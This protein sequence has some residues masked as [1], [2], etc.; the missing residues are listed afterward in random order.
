MTGRHKSGEVAGMAG[1]DHQGGAHSFARTATET[2]I[3]FPIEHTPNLE[4][5]CVPVSDASLFD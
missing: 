1:M 4:Q 5:A 2:E 3:D